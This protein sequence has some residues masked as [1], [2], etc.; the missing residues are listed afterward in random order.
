MSYLESEEK[1]GELGGSEAPVFGRGTGAPKKV[2]S[3]K[4]GAPESTLRIKYFVANM[5]DEGDRLFAESI[6]TNS[7]E[8]KDVPKVVGDIAVIRESENFDKEGNYNL[9]IKYIELVRTGSSSLYTPDT[10]GKGSEPTPPALAADPSDTS[11][12]SSI[13]DLDLSAGIPKHDY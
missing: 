12:D 4:K 13:A 2:T 7:L 8:C 11:D 1:L 6:M 9:L 10:V 5:S 3:P